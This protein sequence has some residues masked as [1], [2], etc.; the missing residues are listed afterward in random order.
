MSLK[1]RFTKALRKKADRGFFGY[2]VATLAFYGPDDKVAT[3]VAVAIILAKDEEPAFLERW[4]SEGHD[5]RK[6]PNVSEQILK[7]IRAH[8]AK[9]VGMADRIIGCPHEEG[10]D[11][12]EGSTCPKCPFWAKRD[13]WSGEVVQ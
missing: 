1:D 6:D 8:E 9:S 2:P 7:F 10:V 5:V 3:K 11:Y 4:F 12:P 13:R